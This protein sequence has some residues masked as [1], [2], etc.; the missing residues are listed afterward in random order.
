[1]DKTRNALGN[2]NGLHG[3]SIKIRG[4]LNKRYIYVLLCSHVSVP[5]P[6]I[7]HY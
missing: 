6:V 3:A 1:M 4:E 5:A 2:E 7:I